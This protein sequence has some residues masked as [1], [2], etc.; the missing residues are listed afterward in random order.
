MLPE[1]VLKRDAYGKYP[2][3]DKI[4]KEDLEDL[5]AEELENFAIRKN[6]EELILS[7]YRFLFERLENKKK[8]VIRHYRNRLLMNGGDEEDA[9]NCEEN[10][11][12]WLTSLSENEAGG[13]SEIKCKYVVQKMRYLKLQMLQGITPFHHVQGIQELVSFVELKGLLVKIAESEC[14]HHLT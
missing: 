11:D 4:G 2:H 1:K 7:S 8:E 12:R 14:M 5:E 10:F 13:S 9:E 6:V 3:L